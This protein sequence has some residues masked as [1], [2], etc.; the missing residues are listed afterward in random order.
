MDRINLVLIAVAIM[1]V[2]VFTVAVFVQS[3]VPQEV[4]QEL[5]FTVSGTNDCLRFLDRHVQTCYI[6]FKTGANEQ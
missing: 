2:I 4:Q 6:P 1:A 5:D 3:S